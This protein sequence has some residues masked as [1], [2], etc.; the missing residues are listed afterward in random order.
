MKIQIEGLG[1]KFQ[2]EWIFKNLNLSLLSGE[3]VAITGP[4]G[5]GK[6]TLLQIIAGLQLPTTGQCRYSISDTTLVSPEELYKHISIAAPYLELIE[7][8]TLSEFLKFHF[9]FKKLKKGYTI[10]DILAIAY[11]E[12]HQSKPIR[13]FSSGMKQRLK[14]AIAFYAENKIVFLDEPTS[15]LDSKGIKWY[16]QEINNILPHNIVII[17]SNQPYEY[18]F[19]TSILNINNF[20]DK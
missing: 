19:C 16:H 12:E 3:S 15:N 11:L 10:K 9:G 13:H 18:D 8:F 7:E 20:K 1:K 14:L 17:G 2:K 5:S 6:S 4:N